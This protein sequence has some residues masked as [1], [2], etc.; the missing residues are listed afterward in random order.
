MTA[1]DENTIVAEL[2]QIDANSVRVQHPLDP[3]LLERLDAAGI[4]VWQEI[5]PVEGAGSWHSTTPRLLAEAEQQARVAAR[6]AV[7]HPSIFAWDL[8][9]EI[10]RNGKDAD[11]VHY[12]QATARW[13]HAFDPT[14]MVAVDI[15]GDHPPHVAGRLYNGIDA[16]A[17]TD[18][19]GWYDSPQRLARPAASG[20]AL[21]PGGHGADL[22]RPRARDQRVR[23]RIQR[24][25][26][27]R[28]A[29]LLR[30]PV[31]PAGRAHLGLC[32]RPATN[33]DVRVAAARLSPEPRLPGRL[34][35]PRLPHIRLIQGLI[36]KGLFTYGGHPK[37]AV[38]VVALA[39]LGG[40]PLSE[41]GRRGDPERG[42]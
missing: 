17:E 42:A 1:A 37:P 36:Q 16:I 23:G 41:L 32:G 22:P 40:P 12:V 11:E 19:S 15:W 9:D 10:A 14:R 25:Q 3:A 24:P 38:P 13:L 34:D 26:P 7:L 39:M 8:C 6:A 5:G 18:Y 30:L 28:G 20:N 33:G 21:A 29:R 2:K 35:P 31:A 4:L 27:R